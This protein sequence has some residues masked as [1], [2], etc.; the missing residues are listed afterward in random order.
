MIPAP[1]AVCA[2]YA[3][4]PGKIMIERVNRWERIWSWEGGAY[5]GISCPLWPMFLEAIRDELLPW[6]LM[7]LG[8]DECRDVIL[9]RR[10]FGVYPKGMGPVE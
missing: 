4:N 10:L 5:A 6:R 1:P 8:I 3:E 7:V 2:Y 9:V